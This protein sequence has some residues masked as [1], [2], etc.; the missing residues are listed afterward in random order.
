MR[1]ALLVALFACGDNLAPGPDPHCADWHQWGNNASHTGVSCASGQALQRML[2][3][4]V[5][6]PYTM[7]EEYDGQGDLFVHY[8]VPLIDGDAVYVMTK[9]GTY[10][11]CHR[12][13]P[14][15]TPDCSQPD[16]LYRL[17]TQVWQEVRY[18]WHGDALVMDWMQ[19]SDWK[20]EPGIDFEPMFQP[21][22]ARGIVAMPGAD[23]SVLELDAQS[24][25]IVRRDQPHLDADTYVAGP[26]TE[27]FGYLYYN[28]LGIDPFQPYAAPSRAW[29]VTVSPD[30]GIATA[31]Y[32]GLVPGAPAPD[33]ACFVHYDE[34]TL[35]KPLP[36]LQSDGRPYLPP[37]RQCGRQLPG[38][39]T[40]PTFA[41][42]GSLYVVTHAQYDAEYSFLVSI[43]PSALSANWASSLRGRL[44]D[45]CG[46]TQ[47]CQDGAPQGVDARTGQLPAAEVDDQSS[48][49]P[50]VMRDGTILYGAFTSYNGDRGHLLAFDHDGHFRAS[51]GFG[52]DTTPAVVGDSVVLKDNTYF[53]P[54]NLTAD[55]GPYNVTMLD[56]SLQPAWQFQNTETKSCIRQAN[57]TLNCVEDHPDGFE[58][59]VNAPAIDR[60]GT[61]F[62]NSEDGNMYA[63]NADGTLRDR[64]F[65]NRSLGA[66][67]TPVALDAS[68]RIYA[69]NNGHLLVVGE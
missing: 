13:S 11:P 48:S 58:W 31:D 50:V 9:A 53:D 62:A 32:A 30:G 54:N 3:D 47:E 60:D 38:I 46:I 4:I 45:G 23:G 8:Q 21:A 55:P 6:D 39:N 41:E 10:T 34:A 42:D 7:Q 5:I 65:L 44:R 22:L 59:C 2:A 26:I 14:M 33:D 24:G 16:E 29:L 28:V 66:A 68:G 35:M 1:A 36:P 57:G 25:E 52:W 17:D 27:R 63:I 40:S 19:T 12:V 51:Y 61:I 18:S 64:F 69:L 56:R 43:D 67:Y 20:P 37:T 15:A 49:N